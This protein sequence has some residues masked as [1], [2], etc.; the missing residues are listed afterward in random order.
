MERPIYTKF[1]ISA[2]I[3]TLN[4][5]TKNY[6]HRCIGS[7]TSHISQ[8]GNW[9][10]EHMEHPIHNKINIYAC[11]RTL[12]NTTKNYRHRYIGSGASHISQI[13]KLGS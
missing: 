10:L 11:M 13:G 4:N 2:C 8:I 1:D 12:N 9:G 7:E 5:T 6:R 3:L